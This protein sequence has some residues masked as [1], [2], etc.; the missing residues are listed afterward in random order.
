M[1][2]RAAPTGASSPSGTSS[3]RRMPVAGASTSFVA[4]SLSISVR[5]SPCCTASPGCLSHATTRP[6]FIASPHL[7]ILKIVAMLPLLSDFLNGS[8]NGWQASVGDDSV[9]LS[10]AKHLAAHR[11]RSFASLRMTSDQRLLPMLLVKLLYR[12]TADLPALRLL[13]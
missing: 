4:F 12:P 2:A 1:R 9:M 8:M 3:Q 11:E 10:A 6:V 13:A 7:G 5:G